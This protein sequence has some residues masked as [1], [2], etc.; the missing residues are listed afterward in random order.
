[1]RVQRIDSFWM[2]IFLILLIFLFGAASVF[3]FI[4]WF[5]IILI[6]VVPLL[7]YLA[8]RFFTWNIRGMN[9]NKK[10]KSNKVHIESASDKDVIDVKVVKK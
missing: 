2:W 5:I 3:K 6:V 7:V 9:I 10:Q 4:F 8:L 1:M